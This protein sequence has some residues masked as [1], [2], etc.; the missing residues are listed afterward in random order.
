MQGA[1]L[2]LFTGRPRT[3]TRRARARSAPT[4]TT[5]CSSRRARVPGKTPALV[6]RIVALVRSRRPDARDRRDHVH[7][8]GRGRAARPHP[9]RARA[10]MRRR[11]DAACAA[12]LDEL[13]ARRDLHAAR[14]RAAA[15]H[16]VPDRGRAAAAHR[17]AA[18]RSR[19]CSRS[20]SA[21]SGSSTSCST[22]P[23]S[24]ASSLLG[25]AP[26]STFKRRCA[27]SPRRSTTTG[28]SS[29]G[30]RATARA[31]R[32]VERSTIGSRTSRQLQGARRLHRRRR[33]AG[34]TLDE[35]DAYAVKLRARR[36]DRADRIEL[37]R[38]R[39][40]V[41]EGGL[42]PGQEQLARRHRRRARRRRPRLDDAAR[43]AARRGRRR[44]SSVIVR[45]RAIAA[46]HRA[47]TPPSARAA[48]E[49]EFH[50]LLVLARG[51]AP[52]PRAR[53][54][55]RGR[56][57]DRYQ[58]LLLD[59]F[60]DTDPIQV[61]LAVAARVGDRRRRRRA[62][63]RASRSTRAAVLR[64][65]P[66]AVDLPVPP[67]RHRDL[68][69][70]RATTFGAAPLLA[71]AQ[72]PH[73][74]R[75][76]ST[77]VNHVFGELIAA[78]PGLA[79]RV[80]SRSSRVRDGRTGRAA[81]V[82]AARRRAPHADEAD[83]DELREREA[84]DV[85]RGRAPRSPSS[86]RCRGRRRPT[87]WRRARLGDICILLPARTSLGVP[88]GRARRRRH[89]VPR[90]DEL[91]RL[92]QPRGPRPARGAPRDR[93]PDRRARAGDARCA[94]RCSAAATTTSS[95]TT[96]STAAAG[97]SRRTAAR[98]AARPTIRSATRSRTSREL[99]DAAAR[100]WRRASCSNASSS[101]RHVL[102]LGAVGRP[103]PRRRAAAP[104]R[105]RPG[106]RV[107]RRGRRDAARL[108]RLGRAARAPKGA[109]VVE[110]VLP[111][112]DDDAVRIIT[113]HGAKGLEFPI[114]IVLGYDHAGAAAA[115]RRAGAVPAGR[116]LRDPPRVGRRTPT[117]S[118]CTSRRRADGL[119]REAPAALRRVHP[120]ARPPRR[121]GAPQGTQA[122]RRPNRVDARG[123]AVER[124]ARARRSPDGVAAPR[125]AAPVRRAPV[126]SP[127]RI[128]RRG[129]RRAK[130]P[131][132]DGRTPPVRRGDRRSR[133]APTTDAR[134]RVPDPGL[135][136]GRPRPRAAAVEQGPLRH[137]DRSRRARGAADRRPRDRRRARRHR[138][139]AG[140]GRRRARPGSDDRARSSAPRSRARPSR[141]ASAGRTGAR[142]TSRCRSK[143]S[144]SRATSTSCTATTTGSSSSTTRPTRSATTPTSTRRL[145]ALPDPGR[146][147]RA[148]R[149]RG[150]RASRSSRACSCSSIPTAH[151]RSRSRAP[152][153]AARSPRCGR[154][155]ASERERPVAARPRLVFAEP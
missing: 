124:R 118:S 18:T 57:R 40:A 126:E 103:L 66:Q 42:G 56:L 92:R 65:R 123:A 63:G 72:L 50:D 97:T 87:Q 115:R 107:R 146:G 8:E 30:S 109:R 67:R 34:G 128:A 49:L 86:G 149:R 6:D 142:C 88:R 98:H 116:R 38:L 29:T 140:R 61:E 5:R 32:A 84:A 9:G 121:L 145:D 106:A 110:T 10:R 68:P 2:S 153:L 75:R 131:S 147:V 58:R 102:E 43:G 37:L 41:V 45:R 24:S 78:E 148:R 95:R 117:S 62:V 119:P 20:R 26:T 101:E 73:R 13:D 69:R 96:S 21:G 130:P 133:V 36:S 127:P 70:R 138:R 94:P 105:R 143:A 99:H 7:R 154:W 83:A 136:E 77:W 79:A 4:S 35:L 23:R 144:R 85:A 16:R 46:V 71:H 90:R 1:Q 93:R 17:G 155:S 25:L 122:R 152:T 12:A 112:T 54:D 33:Q 52:R 76:C 129:K 104:V 151:A 14:V 47:M 44:A 81:R 114:V 59:E 137:R 141:A 139:R 113:V 55:V 27:R 15:P 100:G 64:R 89:P 134:R 74:P 80:P 51:A 132:A 39:E 111:E 19:R 82:D 53:R 91:A 22:T 11:S 135:A 28:T 3:P 150:D 125:V 60:Q 120:R 31:P 108:P 48:G